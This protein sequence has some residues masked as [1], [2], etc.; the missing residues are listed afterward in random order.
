MDPSRGTYISNQGPNTIYPSTATATTSSFQQDYT[1]PYYYTGP[2]RT[3]SS[4]VTDWLQFLQQ[5]PPPPPPSP[6]GT[7]VMKNHPLLE[8]KKNHPLLEQNETG[9]NLT[10]RHEQDHPPIHPIQQLY[11][12]N[13]RPI[14]Q[15]NPRTNPKPAKRPAY[16]CDLVWPA[17]AN[18]GSD[19]FAK[20]LQ[21]MIS[22]TMVIMRQGLHRLAA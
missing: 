22:E 10:K 16:T 14:P 6:P 7:L 20:R 2:N 21:K 5:P 15:P 11:M 12:R 8:Q 19:D 3:S 13:K 9:Q 17:E 1:G 4:T 18:I